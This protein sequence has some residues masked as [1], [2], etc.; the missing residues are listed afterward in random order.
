MSTKGNSSEQKPF[1]ELE[2]KDRCPPLEDLLHNQGAMNG[3]V[4]AL[5]QNLA[6]LATQ[7]RRYYRAYIADAYFLASVMRKNADTWRDF[8]H[9][10]DWND[11]PNRPK[12]DEPERALERAMLEFG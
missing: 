11:A 5:G 4:D 1:V 9:R 2:P 7:Y 10:P 3:A 12:I 6:T 8:C